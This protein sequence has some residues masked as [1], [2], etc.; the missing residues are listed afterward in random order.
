MAPIHVEIKLYSML[1]KYGQEQGLGGQFTLEVEEGATLEQVREQMGIPASRIGR[2]LK[3]AR[4]VGPE[5]VLVDGD[6]I[7]LLPPMI[8]GG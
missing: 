8:S 2:Y 7:D 5:Y 1:K 6:V 3:Q 4:A